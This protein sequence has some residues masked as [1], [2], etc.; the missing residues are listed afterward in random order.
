MIIKVVMIKAK[1]LV[2]VRCGFGKE[3]SN[4]EN[5]MEKLVGIFSKLLIRMK[6]AFF[7]KKIITTSQ[8]FIPGTYRVPKA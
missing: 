3:K 4:E 1:L 8:T 5:Q 6:K 7:G 2:V